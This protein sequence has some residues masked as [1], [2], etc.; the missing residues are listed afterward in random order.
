[1]VTVTANEGQLLEL[2]EQL[3][4]ELQVRDNPERRGRAKLK[5][6]RYGWTQEPY[7]DEA[8]QIWEDASRQAP[9]DIHTMHHLAIMYHARAFD[10][11]QS[12]NPDNADGDWKRALELWHHLCEN[13]HFWEDLFQGIEHT[14]HDL[15]RQ[16]K[17]EFSRQLLKIHFDIAIDE[18]TKHHRARRHIKFAL[19]SPFP[20]EIKD[21]VRSNG[22]QSCTA[23]LPNSI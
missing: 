3:R 14:G 22:Y 2:L 8:F 6:N 18:D 1:M 10:L 13:E 11:E 15:H 23:H 21:T 16:V 5:P 12:N 19:D 4:A 7:T 17:E 9:D 20:Q